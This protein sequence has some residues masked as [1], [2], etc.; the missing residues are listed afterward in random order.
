[1][2]KQDEPKKNLKAPSIKDK[3]KVVN[4]APTGPEW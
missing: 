2:A 4:K 1:M 3:A